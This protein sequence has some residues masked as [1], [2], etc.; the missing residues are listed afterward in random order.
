MGIESESLATKEIPTVEPNPITP[1]PE[2]EE[3][4]MID[5]I[6]NGTSFL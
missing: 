5:L 3:L 1:V 4:S 2:T 6:P